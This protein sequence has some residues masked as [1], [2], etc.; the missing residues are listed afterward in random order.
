M[1]LLYVFFKLLYKN[2]TIKGL[3]Y[4]KYSTHM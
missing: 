1:F 3:I 2:A 4:S